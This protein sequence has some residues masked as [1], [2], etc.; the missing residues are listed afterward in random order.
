MVFILR[1]EFTINF[2]VVALSEAKPIGNK[3]KYISTIIL[4]DYSN[5]SIVGRSSSATVKPEPYGGGGVVIL[6]FAGLFYQ[7]V[8]FRFSSLLGLGSQRHRENFCSQNR[9]L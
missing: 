1:V 3:K 6:S 9:L 2:S 5:L 4:I 8:H 7:S